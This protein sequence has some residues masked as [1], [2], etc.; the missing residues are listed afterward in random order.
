MHVP[1]VDPQPEPAAPIVRE[2]AHSGWSGQSLPVTIVPGQR[3]DVAV[4]LRNTGTQTWR[5]GDPLGTVLLGAPLDS[6]R[7]IASGLVVGTLYNDNRYAVSE[8][9]VVPP[10]SLATF[11]VRLSAPPVPG[12]YRV[13][14]R[15]V[16]E[17]VT[18]LEDEGI[19]VEVVVR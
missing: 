18:W 19:Y 9:L 16:M 5:R 15:P 13:P 10:G 6:T 4:L 2:G 8:E 17:G 11:W 7:D 14:L 3:V 1:Q 12:R